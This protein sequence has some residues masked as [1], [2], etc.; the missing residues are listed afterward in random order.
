MCGPAASSNLLAVD[1]DAHGEIRVL[2]AGALREAGDGSRLV[3]VRHV[4]ISLDALLRVGA[5]EANDL[6]NREAVLERKA[7]GMSYSP[8][9]AS[10]WK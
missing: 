7:G 8:A 5:L 1:P 6:G 10:V 9:F 4:G 3:L 2:G